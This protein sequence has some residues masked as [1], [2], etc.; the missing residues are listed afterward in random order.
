M[1]TDDTVRIEDTLAWRFAGEGRLDPS[2]PVAASGH[3]EIA[4][5]PEVV[6]RLLHDV[7]NWPDIRADV[8]DVVVL[9]GGAFT[10]SAGPIPVR[11]RFVLTEPGCTLT[12]CTLAA[13][14]EAVHVY[15][16]EA[17]GSGTR[18]DAAESMSGPLAGPAISSA[19]LQSQIASWLEGIKA[20]AETR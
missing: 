16:F 2:A 1:T 4:R 13:G 15:H 5:A 19:Q 20:L 6:W 7:T 11:S 18:L 8:Q 12:W 17:V 9:D 3:I 10:W 14:L